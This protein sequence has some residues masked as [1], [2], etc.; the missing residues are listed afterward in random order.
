MMARVAANL[1]MVAPNVLDDEDP[2]VHQNRVVA[3]LAAEAVVG[4]LERRWA[5]ME[6]AAQVLRWVF[7]VA[8]AP[9]RFPG[10]PSIS[11]ALALLEYVKGSSSRSQYSAA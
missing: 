1:G 2:Y 8:Q 9:Q 3:G 11:K 10:G 5:M 6:R 7:N 4:E